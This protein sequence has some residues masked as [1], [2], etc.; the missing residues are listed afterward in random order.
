MNQARVVLNHIR[1]QPII[2]SEAIHLSLR[3]KPERLLLTIIREAIQLHQ[4]Q[5]LEAVQAAQDLQALETA[6][7]SQE[8]IHPVVPHPA[9]VLVVVP[10]IHPVLPQVRLPVPLHARFPVVPALEGDREIKLF[11]L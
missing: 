9:E 4:D 3:D 11:C 8:V 7:V 5:V 2:V 6:A 10:V 1:E